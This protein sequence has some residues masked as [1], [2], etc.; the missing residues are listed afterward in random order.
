[1]KEQFATREIS[2]ILKSKGFDEPCYAHFRD[3]DKEPTMLSTGIAGVKYSWIE[4][5]PILAP[6]WQQVIDWLRDKHFIY[7]EVEKTNF[8]NDDFLVKVRRYNKN[9]RL[10]KA[11]KYDSFRTHSFAMEQAIIKSLKLI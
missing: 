10:C 8:K 6:L 1:M 3:N 9:D 11:S 2:E 5:S 7:T 4:E